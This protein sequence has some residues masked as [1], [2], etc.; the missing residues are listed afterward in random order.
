MF[1]HEGDPQRVAT[2]LPDGVMSAERAV[3]HLTIGLLAEDGWSVRL[4][5][6]ANGAETGLQEAEDQSARE[7]DAVRAVSHLVVGF[8]LGTAAAPAAVDRR[9]PALWLSPLLRD[10][11]LRAA[12]EH[13]LEPGL[14]VG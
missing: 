6:W 2:V 5:R 12:L 14:V 8:G 11:R 10:E 9:L 3:L 1:L 13:T 7:L 4:V